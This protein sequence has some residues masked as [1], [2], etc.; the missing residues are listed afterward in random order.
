MW[1]ISLVFS[2]YLILLLKGFLYVNIH[3]PPDQVNTHQSHDQ[4]NDVIKCNLVYGNCYRSINRHWYLG[5]ECACHCCEILSDIWVKKR[6][7][8]D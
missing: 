3:Q 7:N 5:V 4:V 1:L 2:I 8:A 6:R